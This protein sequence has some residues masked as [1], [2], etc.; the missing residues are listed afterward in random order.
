MSIP[1][2]DMMKKTIEKAEKSGRFCFLYFITGEQD[3]YLIAT[4]YNE[5]W[6][7]SAFFGGYTVL[8]DL[9]KTHLERQSKGVINKNKDE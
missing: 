9:G 4:E 8:S 3:S 7:F 5:N 1:F 2:S 6:L